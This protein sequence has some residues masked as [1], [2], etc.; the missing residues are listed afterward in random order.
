MFVHNK[1]FW[2]RLNK[3]ESDL[4]YKEGNRRG[5]FSYT[6]LNC[7]INAIQLTPV[8][9]AFLSVSSV[10]LAAYVAG[11]AIILGSVIVASHLP[12]TVFT[13]RR[14]SKCNDL[15]NV[16]CEPFSE[17][18]SSN[19]NTDTKILLTTNNTIATE[20][21]NNS[22]VESIDL[23]NADLVK[24]PTWDRWSDSNVAFLSTS[25]LQSESMKNRNKVFDDFTE[26]SINTEPLETDLFLH[27]KD[28]LVTIFNR[29]EISDRGFILSLQNWRHYVSFIS[30]R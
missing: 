17:C 10:C 5:W 15:S 27:G 6:E 24:Y 28:E 9:Q 13:S 25:E 4:A 20:L 8:I 19:V 12:G 22:R 2:D 29:R 26:F 1:D 16:N 11:V 3:L 30:L 21:Y 14:L 18:Q 23:K 7:L